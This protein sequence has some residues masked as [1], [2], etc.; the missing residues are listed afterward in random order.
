M[1]SSC[2]FLLVLL[3][4]FLFVGFAFYF[5]VGFCFSFY[6]LLVFKGGDIRYRLLGLDYRGDNVVSD[7][8]QR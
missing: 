1:H 6:F 3:F 2:L 5:F 4:T 7:G 8:L